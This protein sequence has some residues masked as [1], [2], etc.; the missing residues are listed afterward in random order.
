MKAYLHYTDRTRSLIVDFKTAGGKFIVTD[1]DFLNMKDVR[2]LILV[3]D[4]AVDCLMWVSDEHVGSLAQF[5]I[6]LPDGTE[7]EDIITV[8][9]KGVY[10]SIKIA[11]NLEYVE[12]LKQGE[13]KPYKVKSASCNCPAWIFSKAKPKT[14][15]HCDMLNMMGI[16]LVEPPK[17]IILSKEEKKKWSDAFKREKIK[18]KEAKIWIIEN[19]EQLVLDFSATTLRQWFEIYEKVKSG[20]TTFTKKQ[21]R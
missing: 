3:K 14:C 12:F 16:E 9:L 18:D 17:K 21:E 19:S 7:I 11:R 13:S 15:K 2:N 4:R 6:N 10:Y 20:E 1:I 5:L 8:E